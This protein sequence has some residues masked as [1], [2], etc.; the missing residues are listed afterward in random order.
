MSKRV[1]D[2][3]IDK[4]YQEYPPLF[5]LKVHCC[6]VHMR[7]LLWAQTCTDV[8][9]VYDRSKLIETEAT[10]PQLCGILKDNVNNNKRV[11]MG[12]LK[13][14]QKRNDRM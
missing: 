6:T 9:D 14:K 12:D 5:Y 3:K 2:F 11:Y 4:K 8:P 7:N 13:Y 1:I 10:L